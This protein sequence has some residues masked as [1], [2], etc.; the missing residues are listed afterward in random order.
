MVF[1]GEKRE[2]SISWDVEI[3]GSVGQGCTYSASWRGPGGV[4]IET[5]TQIKPEW[6]FVWRF[7]IMLV[8][9]SSSVVEAPGVLMT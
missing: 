5:T 1:L 9:V 2:Q 8:S 7:A 6:K 3:V 4:P